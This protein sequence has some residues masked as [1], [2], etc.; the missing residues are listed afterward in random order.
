M[1]KKFIYL[2]VISWLGFG[3]FY[4]GFWFFNLR[5]NGVYADAEVIDTRK[6]TVGSRGRAGDSHAALLKFVTGD[7]DVRTT[8]ISSEFSGSEIGDVVGVY[9]DP[10]QPS[11]VIADTWT[12]FIFAMVYVLFIATACIALI[13]F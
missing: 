6:G 10:A 8:V 3:V 4:E 2:V 1:W 12:H 9:Y 7:G 5:I 11:S 13:A